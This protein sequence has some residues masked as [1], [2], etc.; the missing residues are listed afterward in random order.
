MQQTW[1]WHKPSWRRSP[2]TPPKSHQNLHR[3]GKQTLGGHKQTSCAPGPRRKDQWPHK[4]LTQLFPFGMPLKILVSPWAAAP[5][6]VTGILRTSRTQSPTSAKVS[7]MLT[8]ASLT[9]DVRRPKWMSSHSVAT[10]YQMS[11]SSSPLKPWRLPVF[12]PTST[13]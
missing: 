7:L 13:W 2:F 3:T 9:C 6:G 5:P 11:M 1:V 8:F 10:Q 12:V 4:R